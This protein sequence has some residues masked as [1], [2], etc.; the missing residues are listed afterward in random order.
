MKTK[1]FKFSV[2][3]ILIGLFVNTNSVAQD[4]KA[5]DFKMLYK[6]T[7]TKQADNSRLLEV[8]FIAR[9]K[10]NRKNKIP[11]FDAEINFYNITEGENILLG[12]AKTNKKGLAT[13]TLSEN[14][15]YFTDKDGYI[16]LKAVFEKTAAIKLY[17]KSISVKDLMLDLN[18]EEID[19]VKTVI[20]KAY[21]LDSLNTKIPI[22]D[23]EVIFSI[24]GMI[25]NMPIEQATIEDGRYEFEFPTN[26]P[27]NI[28]GNL[29]V[30]V[31]VEDHEEFGNVIQKKTIN[32]GNFNKK[33]TK[34]E[35]TLWSDA[36]PIW[37]YIVL[38]VLL[39]GVWANY[40]YTI[41]NLFK[42]KKEG[43]ILEENIENQI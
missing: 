25:S 27:G 33:I 15:S 2:I 10:K 3:A 22:T 36:A 20:L 14:Q 12:T 28:D 9:H 34:K 38:T 26:I 11:I 35:N 29:D 42:M 5:K 17:E 7:T 13:L 21:T 30:F 16:N 4:N 19:S 37:M 31:S 24:G 32:W 43:K 40:A 6:F 23:A 18:L 1:L 39:V 41:F 8:S